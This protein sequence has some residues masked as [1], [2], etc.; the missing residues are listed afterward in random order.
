MKRNHISLLSAILTESWHIHPSSAATL[1]PLILQLLQGDFSANLEESEIREG[2]SPTADKF[3]NNFS[4]LNPTPYINERDTWYYDNFPVLIKNVVVIPIIGLITQED[5]WNSAGTKTIMG[6]YEKAKNDP[7]VKAVIE[8]KNTQGG[9]VFGTRALA[10][11]KAKY[12][13]PIVGLCEAME[14]SAG[15]YIGSTDDYKFAIS[16][17]CIIGSCGVMNTFQDW[18][19]YFEKQ[20][21]KISDL[22]SD[23]SPL[24]NDA[25]RKAVKGD[26]KG[27]TEGILHSFDA[28][29]MDFMQLHRPNISKNA[30]KGA[31]FLSESAI[32]NGLIDE[33]G[34]F[35][36][37]LDK[38][39]ELSNTKKILKTKSIQMS[40]VLM[41]VPAAL[42]A[43]LK[44]LG[45]SEAPAVEVASVPATP[46]AAAV[47]P[48]EVPAPEAAIV[49]TTATTTMEETIA[50]LAE[51]RIELN[52]SQ[53]NAAQ[54][55]GAFVALQAAAAAA[56]PAIARSV[57]RQEGADPALPEV[58]KIEAG[59]MEG[60]AAFKA[61]IR[62]LK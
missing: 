23:T 51:M 40:N 45:C 4:L 22:Y 55:N 35:Q 47:P 54:V 9:Q 41:S 37:A 11:Y 14:C 59:V 36:A 3:L 60:E 46:E 38:A 1:M 13:K 62:G 15:L 50:M 5:L 58:V 30:L 56:S 31:D 34:D 24:K 29:F 20:G 39:N 8:I 17:E 19:G 6:W 49:P 42:A 18:S 57:A 33:I 28:S 52:A 43:G 12:P 44:I 16:T 21:I 2:L 10:D 25:Y 7:E 53:A 61:S 27:Y 32:E 48:V 26:F